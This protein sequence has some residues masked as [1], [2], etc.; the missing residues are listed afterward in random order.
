MINQK[1]YIHEIRHR[2]PFCNKI[3]YVL[4]T[5][6]IYNPPSIKLP[7]DY[8]IT[9]IENEIGLIDCFTFCDECGKRYD[10]KIGIKN[11]RIENIVI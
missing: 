3:N 2:C 1:I 10:K 4:I 7:S 8:V 6:Q 9:E 11:S 5:H